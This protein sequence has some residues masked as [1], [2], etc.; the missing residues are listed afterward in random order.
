MGADMAEKQVLNQHIT[1]R[2]MKIKPAS[3][4]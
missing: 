2:D 3:R 1:V 4:T